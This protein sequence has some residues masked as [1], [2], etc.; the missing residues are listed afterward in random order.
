MTTNSNNR[1]K[2]FKINQYQ[3]NIKIKQTKHKDQK[4]GEIIS[5]M[6]KATK[7]LWEIYHFLF[8]LPFERKL[9][10]LPIVRFSL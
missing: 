1:N 6:K 5:H 8:Q 4:I 10:F 2:Y 9:T 3:L 7:H